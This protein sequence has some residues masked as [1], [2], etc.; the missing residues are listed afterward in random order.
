MC[1]IFTLLNN[2]NF[3]KVSDIQDN[4]NK[5]KGRGPEFSSLTQE[6]LNTHVGFHRLAINGIDEQSHQPI[7]I[8]N[9]VLICNGEIYNYKELFKTMNITPETNSDCEVIS[10]LYIRYGIEQTLSLL[11]GVFS[12]ILIDKNFSNDSKIFIARDPYGV[13]PLYIMKPIN[14]IKFSKYHI[15]GFASE[16]KSLFQLHKTLNIENDLKNTRNNTKLAKYV[17]YTIEQFLPG[18]YMSFTMPSNNESYWK[19]RKSIQYHSHGFYSN[20]LNDNYTLPKILK[21]IRTYLINAV[22]KRCITTDRPV[23]CLLSGG[24]DSSIITALVN[25]YCIQNSMPT[26]ETYSIGLEGAED[27]QY[28]RKVADHLGTKHTEIILSESQFLNA[29]PEVI[30][31][32]ESFDTTTIRASI[33]NWLIGKYISENSQ[34]K[35]IFNGDGSDELMGGYLYMGKANDEFEF[36]RECRR[37]LKYIHTFDVLRSDKCISSHGLEPRT[38]FLDRSWVNYYLSIPTNIRFH[39]LNN[40]PEK[41]LL[42]TAF[43][44]EEFKNTNNLPLLP[45]EVLWRRKEAFSDGVSKQTRSLY[46]IIQDYVDTQISDSNERVFNHLHP[47]TKEQLYYRTIFEKHYPGV[48]HILPYFWMPKYVD[49]TDSSARSLSIYK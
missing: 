41:Y 33:G 13:R 17:N 4:F 46:E 25:E 36:D 38:P 35:V 7:H 27:L 21:Y 31:G 8:Q 1:G 26:L 3:I 19:D 47:Q 11:D 49:A 34:A 48:S 45:K 24:L 14:D 40:K 2:H 5:G 22:N 39:T 16:L 10:H 30:Q 18:T 12:F 43:S 6:F 9:T 28:A 42:R 15:Y 37:L 23:A 29:I 44:E 20:L 32:I